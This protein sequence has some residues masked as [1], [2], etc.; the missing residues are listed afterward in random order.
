MG[1]RNPPYSCPLPPT[2]VLSL[3]ECYVRPN[4]SAR[5]TITWPGK[6]RTVTSHLDKLSIGPAPVGTRGG[7][8]YAVRILKPPWILQWTYRTYNLQLTANKPPSMTALHARPG[9]DLRVLTHARLLNQPLTRIALP[10]KAQ[11]KRNEWHLRLSRC[12]AVFRQFAAAGQSQWSDVRSSLCIGAGVGALACTGGSGP[13]GPS[14]KAGGS[15]GSGGDGWHAGPGHSS[16][17]NVL[18]DVAA[19]D[20]GSSN[21]EEQVVLLDVGGRPVATYA[22]VWNQG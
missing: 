16:I 14:L 22:P 13:N 20:D 12:S 9:G 7:C 17:S 6:L 10:I 4:R 18:S 5:S 11:Q 8:L 15:G 19:V 1:H 2:N 3:N 21:A